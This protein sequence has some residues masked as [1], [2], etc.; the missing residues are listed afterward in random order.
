MSDV[1]LDIFNDVDLDQIQ[2]VKRKEGAL[3][4]KLKEVRRQYYKR[5]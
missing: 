5:K 4:K 2:D 1:D 3:R